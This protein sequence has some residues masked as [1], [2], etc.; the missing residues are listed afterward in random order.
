VR[1]LLGAGTA[2]VSQDHVRREMVGEHDRAGAT[3]P[4]LLGAITE[5]LLDRGHDVILEGMMRAPLYRPLVERL[6]TVSRFDTY[7]F[8]LV[9]DPET[10]LS[11]HTERAWSSRISVAEFEEWHADYAKAPDIPGE[12]LL[13]A[14]LSLD[15]L[16]SFVASEVGPRKR[17]VPINA[18]AATP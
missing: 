4:E 1:E 18:R 10:A 13:D 6:A 3:T 14:H 9:V 8:R 12:V 5:F 16:S 7:L 17:P 2:L 15:V 11:R